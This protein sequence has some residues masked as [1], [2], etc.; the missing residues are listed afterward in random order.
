MSASLL[1]R[2]V[3]DKIELDEPAP[4]LEGQR[5]RVTVEA[6]GP[7]ADEHPV[8]RAIRLA[9]PDDTPLTAGERASIEAAKSGG[10]WRTSDEIRAKIAESAR[11]P[12]GK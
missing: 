10:V 5:I 8:A 11:D 7:E 2:V 4:N 1:G 6:I 12:N 9:S 3:G